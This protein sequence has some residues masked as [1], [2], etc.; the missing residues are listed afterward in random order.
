M[1]PDQVTETGT[2]DRELLAGAGL[3]TVEDR[4]EDADLTD[5]MIGSEQKI[6]SNR[7]KTI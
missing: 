2:S 6:V 4:T 7:M 3:Q 1:K 5:L